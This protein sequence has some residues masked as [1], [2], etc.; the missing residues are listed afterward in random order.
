MTIWQARIDKFTTK[1][2][3]SSRATFIGEALKHL[4]GDDLS[5]A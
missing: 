2:R 1:I 5:P 4:L 3:E